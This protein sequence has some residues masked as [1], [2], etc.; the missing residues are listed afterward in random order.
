MLYK[1]TSSNIMKYIFK[2]KKLDL[3][4]FTIFEENARLSYFEMWLY[5][6]NK[7]ISRQL[8]N[9]IWQY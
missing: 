1:M 3:W 5:Y 4:P 9:E 8:Y 2:P 7:F 6:I